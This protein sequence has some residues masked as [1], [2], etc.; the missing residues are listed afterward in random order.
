MKYRTMGFQPES[1][2]NRIAF[3]TGVV[4]GLYQFLLNIHL[5]TDFWSKLIEAA[6][7]AAVCGF[8]G[9]LGKE[10]YKLVRNSLQTYFRNRKNKK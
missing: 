6:I 1:V 2:D 4:A 7:T 8:V 3:I 10:L 9:V 5:P